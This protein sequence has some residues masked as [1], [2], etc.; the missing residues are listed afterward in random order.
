MVEY[1]LVANLPVSQPVKNF[2]NRLTFGEVMGKS[3]VSCFLLRHCV[4]STRRLFLKTLAAK[5]GKIK[6]TV[7]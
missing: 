6:H 4:H 7:Q 5:G 3:L 2:E 1:E